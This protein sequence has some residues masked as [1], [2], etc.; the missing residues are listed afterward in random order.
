MYQINKFVSIF[1]IS[2]FTFPGLL[3]SQTPKGND[4]E[5]I[6]TSSIDLGYGI[7]V[8]FT[9]NSSSISVL[10]GIEL[11]KSI[12]INPGKGLYGR[13]P[14]LNVKNNGGSPWGNPTMHIRGI[15]T[16][17]N[18]G[19][20]VLVD[21]F[22]RP[23]SALSVDE[24]DKI[25]ILK[26]ASALAKFGTR[27]ANGVILITTKQGSKNRNKIRVSYEHGI[28]KAFRL[29]EFLNSF[30]Y[31][32]AVNEAFSYE[33]DSDPIFS[34]TALE[35]FKKG[36]APYF[37]PD[38]NW[39]DETLRKW[40]DLDRFNITFQGEKKKMN[41]FLVFNYQN[42]NGL[43]KHV[44]NK[45][46]FN[47]Q[48]KF[49]QFNFRS[50]LT[51]D[52]TKNTKLTA[53]LSGFLGQTRAP[54]VPVQ[55]IMNMLYIIPPSAFPVMTYNNNWGGDDIF[56]N[57]NPV[58]LSYATGY[59]SNKEQ[60]LLGDLNLNQKLDFILPGLSAEVSVAY[61][62]SG[63]F[64]DNYVQDFKYEVLKLEPSIFTGRF[65][66]LSTTHG[67]NTE[68][69]FNMDMR[70]PYRHGTFIGK[71]D[72]DKTWG[73]NIFNSSLLYQFDKLVEQGQNNVFSRQLVLGFVH[74]VKENKY[75][76]DLTLAAGGSSVLPE[77]HRF[78]L[79]PALSLGWEMTKEN[80]FRSDG[81]FNYLKVR[82]S[83]GL[84]GN[85]RIPR[86]LTIAQYNGSSPYYVGKNNNI[87]GGLAE[88]RL[89]SE[90]VKP[91]LA[92]K[93]NLGFDGRVF[94]LIDFSLDV[95][96][97]NRRNILIDPSGLISG[98]I[99]I[100]KPLTT[101]GIVHNKGIEFGINFHNQERDFKYDIRGNFAFVRNKIIENGE[102]FRPYDYMKT[103]GRPIGQARGQLSLGFF[104]NEEEIKNSP[105]QL[106]SDVKPGD[107]KY[108]DLNNDGFIDEF[109]VSHFGYS[110]SNPEIDYSLSLDFSYKGFGIFAILQGIEHYTLFLTTKGV[111]WPNIEGTET[112]SNLYYK[113]RWTPSNSENAVFPILSATSNS[114]N[115]RNNDLWGKNGSFLK[116]RA[117]GIYYS[118][119]DNILSKL[120]IEG[121]KLFLKGEN[122]FSIDHVKTLDPESVGV[123]YPTL[124][125]FS[126]GISI[127]LK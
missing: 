17:R 111:Y 119:N 4:D 1:L 79:Y 87:K 18:A 47:T 114:N 52:L 107:I 90:S 16:F 51:F 88:S 109:D 26:D 37:Y 72:Y 105:D 69:S 117:A 54:R 30:N 59:R 86:N 85:D 80:W 76:A 82:G 58:A 34:S 41:Y 75:F 125:S 116:M 62:N 91:E 74:F 110:T 73:K 3:Y 15:S 48:F 22:E 13:L 83:F 31:T 89:P 106:F 29:P 32:R 6:D 99:G 60:T 127:G 71:L 14:G 8:P 25:E 68:L 44:K 126:G 20:L 27:G 123:S 61:D 70:H 19:M 81:V 39:I 35:H 45:S 104:E 9:E 28:Q 57:N 64:Y 124:T 100:A 23:L 46:G 103:I 65:D 11:K 55:D 53:H 21:G 112:I 96:Y 84:A 115:Y 36:D 92:I 95:F 78:S 12:S 120:K 33:G 93:Y 66:T 121:L 50:N 108:S 101:D 10:D 40:G 94:K 63:T 97:E 43:F 77:H 42:T 118:F 98:V 49:S 113:N 102:Q 38:I 67:E 56:T 122:L 24:I 7:S 2:F 5:K